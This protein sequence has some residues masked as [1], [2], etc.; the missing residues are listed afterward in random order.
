MQLL[1]D[2]EVCRFAR[3]VRDNVD[4]VK[5]LPLFFVESI[6]APIADRPLQWSRSF[7]TK[8]VVRLS[9]VSFLGISVLKRW[10]ILS[11]EFSY[12]EWYSSHSHRSQ[13]SYDVLISLRKRLFVGDKARAVSNVHVRV[14]YTDKSLL[15]VSNLHACDI[16]RPPIPIRV[17]ASLRCNSI[18]YLSRCVLNTH[19]C[20]H[21]WR[22]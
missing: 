11:I 21:N 18:T 6:L 12:C 10:I 8:F 4:G 9:A 19:D 14:T 3:V 15:I 7:C 5:R 17:N 22:C 2:N 13:Y 16:T 20:Y 1:S